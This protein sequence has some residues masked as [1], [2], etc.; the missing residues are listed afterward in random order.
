M[1]WLLLGI[2][3]VCFFAASFIKGPQGWFGT[4]L[5]GLAIILLLMMAGTAWQVSADK[6]HPQPLGDYFGYALWGGMLLSGYWLLG[7]VAGGCVGLIGRAAI[8]SFRSRGR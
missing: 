4:A 3:F 7:G 2:P 1:I 5:V 6:A 8:R